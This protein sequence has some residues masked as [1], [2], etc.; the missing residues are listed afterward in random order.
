MGKDEKKEMLI[1]SKIDEI[2]QHKGKYIIID[3]FCILKCEGCERNNKKSHY[4]DFPIIVKAKESIYPTKNKNGDSLFVQKNK[5]GF[6]VV[7][8]DAKIELFN[9]SKQQKYIN[10]IV[11]KLQKIV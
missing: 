4:D 5:H 3:T 10:K 8:T 11:S 7:D 6:I 1:K 2:N 9:G